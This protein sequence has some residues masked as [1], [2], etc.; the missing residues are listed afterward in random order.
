MSEK[1][2]AKPVRR[3]ATRVDRDFRAAMRR[4]DRTFAKPN[5]GRNIWDDIR[6]AGL[7]LNLQATRMNWKK[8]RGG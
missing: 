4:L 3:G 5:A 1:K 7:R 2:F 8:Q 6:P